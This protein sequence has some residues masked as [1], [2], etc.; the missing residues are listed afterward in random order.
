MGDAVLVI[1]APTSDHGVVRDYPVHLRG[2]AVK[3]TVVVAELE[4]S[5]VGAFF[6]E[7]ASAWRGAGG[8]L[9]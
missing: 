6:R 9:I 7:L 5:P 1:E 3:A 4:V 2:P 8:L